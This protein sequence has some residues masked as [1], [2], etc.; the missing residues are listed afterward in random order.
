MA[1]LNGGSNGG[2]SGKAG[3]VVGYFQY[4]QWRIRGL[5]KYSAKN[6][7]GS[8]NQNICR[9]RFSKMQDFLG[10]VLPF[11]R[12]GFNLE[13]KRNHNS[14][15]NSAKSW[16]MLNAFNEEGEIDYTA[17]RFSMG[18]LPGAEDA[19]I[20]EQEDQRI[21]SWRDNSGDTGEDGDLREDDQVMIM[22]YDR[23]TRASFGPMS[24]ARRSAGHEI[25]K[26]ERSRHL[27]EHHIWISFISDDRQRIANSRYVGMVKL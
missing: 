8:T 2:F 21:I 15:H 11:I 5:P 25:V 24:G 1:I 14:A 23:E 13:A 9:S 26:I 3:S 19:A 20:E 12:I 18:N 17:F 22:I 16:N 7:K 6:R 10:P 27:I 4:G